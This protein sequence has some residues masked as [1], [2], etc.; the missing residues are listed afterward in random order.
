MEPSGAEPKEGRLLHGAFL[1]CGDRGVQKQCHHVSLRG[2]T[3]CGGQRG[4]TAA[5][6]GRCHIAAVGHRGTK[7]HSAGRT[8]ASGLQA[9]RRCISAEALS[10][11]SGQ[12][13]RCPS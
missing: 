9:V 12:Q 8:S 11:V 4:F 2:T 5:G 6:W 1:W 10:V 7:A 13:P 3:V